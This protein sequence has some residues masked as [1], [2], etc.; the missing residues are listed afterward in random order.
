MGMSSEKLSIILIL[1]IWGDCF[2]IPLYLKKV[3]Q[4]I[5]FTW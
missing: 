1:M 4:M 5:I 2:Y 3:A